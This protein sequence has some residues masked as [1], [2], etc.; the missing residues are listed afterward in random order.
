MSHRVEGRTLGKESDHRKAMLHNMVKSLIDKERIM[1][2]HTR[3]LECKKIAERLVTYGK[4]GTV[5][6]QRLIYSI[7]QDRD[8]VKKMVNEIAPKLTDRNGGYTR[9]LKKGFRR[10]DNAPMS[11][12]E[13]VWYEAKETS[14]EDKKD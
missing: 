8:L 12:I 5:H 11:I 6:Y 3:A 14:K 10:G 9:I 4:K 7:V 13:W 2:T 1:T